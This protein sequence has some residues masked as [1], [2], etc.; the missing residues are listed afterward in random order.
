MSAAIVCFNYTYPSLFEGVRFQAPPHEKRKSDNNWPPPPKQCF[1][2]FQCFS[3]LC[4]NI[5]MGAAAFSSLQL[6]NIVQWGL[7]TSTNCRTILI[8]LSLEGSEWCNFILWGYPANLWS[9]LV[10]TREKLRMSIYALQILK[11]CLY[12]ILDGHR[13]IRR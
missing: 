9:R 6:L 10:L 1:N 12:W 13:N 7:T 3:F 5:V 8:L 4:R 2:I 11:W